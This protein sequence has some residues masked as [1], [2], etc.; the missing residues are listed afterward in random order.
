MRITFLGTSAGTEPMAGRRH[1]SFVVEHNGCVY[2]FDAGEGC[3]YTAHLAGVDLPA[4]RAIFISH[5]HMDHIGGLANLLWSIRKLNTRPEHLHRVSGKTIKVFIPNLDVWSGVMQVLSGT[6]NGFRID[7]TLE[8]RS[9]EDGTIYD[10]RGF[11]VIALHNHHLPPPQEGKPWRSFSFRIEAGDKTVVYS[12][13]VADVRDVDTLV[14]GCDLFLMETGHH[15]VEDVCRYLRDS[16]KIFG[17]LGFIHHGRAIL[18]DPQGE[19]A[20]ATA[21]IGNNVLLTNDG[22]VLEL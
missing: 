4:T 22:M 11:K 1:V 18:A 2:W 7:F 13:D 6:E 5:T 12:G 10:E 14:D 19:L 17:R 9:Y 15:A 3:S 16:K 20:K 8:A 21:I